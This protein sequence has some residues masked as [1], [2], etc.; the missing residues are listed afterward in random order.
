MSADIEQK[1][2]YSGKLDVQELDHDHKSITPKEEIAQPHSELYAEALAR[3]G[4]DGEI[5]PIAEK[6]LKRKLDM[7]I[8]PALGICYF[9]YVSLNMHGRTVE[10]SDGVAFFDA[11]TQCGTMWHLRQ[12]TNLANHRNNNIIRIATAS[13][14]S[15]H[16]H[17]HLCTR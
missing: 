1:S 6:K 9:F 5:D 11:V 15:M 4:I 7:R 16:P 12:P 8:I 2:V 3:Y 13:T 10:E 14:P 17:P